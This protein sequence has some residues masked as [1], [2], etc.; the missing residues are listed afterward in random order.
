MDGLTNVSETLYVP[1]AGR[2]YSSKYS[3]HF[4]YDEVAL[5]IYEKYPEYFEKSL[6][7][8]EYTHLAS[9]MRSKNMDRY[10]QDFLKRNPKG[11]IVN[12]GCGL[13]SLYQRNNNGLAYWFELDFENVLNLRKKFFPEEQNDWFL[14]Y[15]IF[16]TTW[17]EKVREHSTEPILLIAAGLFHY[18]QEEKV[19]EFINSLEAVTPVELVFDAVS[20]FGIKQSRKYMKKMGREDAL[21][22]FSVDDPKDLISKCKVP[23]Q[24]IKNE[25]YYSHANFKSEIKNSTKVKMKISDIFNMV[26]MVHLKI[27]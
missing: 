27:G 9:A 13:E 16:D 8:E 11:S 6:Q 15:S 12:L 19:I 20:S 14:P 7:Q 2:I 3:P 24:L 25:K 10:I 1:M 5:H 17:M 22:Y 26:K 4:F 23:I 21:M 18:F